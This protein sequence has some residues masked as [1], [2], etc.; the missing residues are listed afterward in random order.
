MDWPP[1]MA[2]RI[3]SGDYRSDVVSFS[4]AGQS[5]SDGRSQGRLLHTPEPFDNWRNE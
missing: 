3:D 2:R 5:F 4:K 1:D